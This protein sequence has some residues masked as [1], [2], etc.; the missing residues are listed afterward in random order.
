MFE[1]VEAF[2]FSLMVVIFD[3]EWRFVFFECRGSAVRGVNKRREKRQRKREE[4]KGRGKERRKKGKPTAERKLGGRLQGRKLYAVEGIVSPDLFRLFFRKLP[5]CC[6]EQRPAA[7]HLDENRRRS[8]GSSESS[9]K[10][11]T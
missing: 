5:C 9:R 6:E 8:E 1:E 11:I 3:E 4:K 7:R 10:M 2:A